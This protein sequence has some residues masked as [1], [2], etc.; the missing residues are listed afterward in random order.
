M[1]FVVG[2]FAVVVFVGVLFAFKRQ[3]VAQ[4]PK[5]Q[6]CGTWEEVVLRKKEFFLMVRKAQSLE[7]H[8]ILSSKATVTVNNLSY[9]SIGDV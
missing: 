1:S 5:S 2:C 8:K 6:E 9:S 4:F 3:G 7:K